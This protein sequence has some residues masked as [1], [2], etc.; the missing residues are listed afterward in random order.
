MAYLGAYY[1]LIWGAFHTKKPS[2]ES[3]SSSLCRG[4]SAPSRKYEAVPSRQ[5][6]LAL[7]MQHRIA[8]IIWRKAKRLRCF[9]IT[10]KRRRRPKFQVAAL[11][12]FRVNFL[13]RFASKP[14]FYWVVPLNCS[15]NSLVL[16][17]RFFGFGVPFW[18][19]FY[20]IFWEHIGRWGLLKE[21]KKNPKGQESC[22][23][24][25]RIFWTIRGHNPIKQ[26]FW[27]KLH[28][29]VHPKFGKIFVATSSL[30]YLCCPWLLP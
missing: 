10:P 26:G 21:P 13:V 25:Q 20:V 15:E 16:F 30:G 1:W 7:P 27:G 24:H 2:D 14:F 11:P 12:N 6:M 29:E 19:S 23:Q 3:H 18:P 5:G 9:K 17:V 22:E 8:L 28:K 4:Q